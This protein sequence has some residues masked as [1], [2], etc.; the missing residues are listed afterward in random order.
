[1]VGILPPQFEFPDKNCADVI[2]PSALENYDISPTTAVRL[3][4]VVARLKPGVRTE[5]VIANLDAV[6]QRQ[7]ATYPA[8]FS[9]MLKGTHP[10]VMPLHERLVGK[11]RPALLVLLGAILF[12]LLI[13]CVN[14]A[15]L[16]LA[17]AVPRER[18]IAI[19]GA[20]GASRWQIVRQL[21]VENVL[22]AL[23]GGA[24]GFLVTAFDHPVV[25]DERPERHSS[26][27]RLTIDSSSLRIRNNHFAV[28]G[29][30]VRPCTN[31]GRFS[32]V[33]HRDNQRDWVD[34]RVQPKGPSF[35]WSVCCR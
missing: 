5:E 26:P 34:E 30:P 6:N 27:C 13:V 8:M 24:L 35:P 14:I 2:V 4:Q 25:E 9:G 10:V 23:A 15:S 33:G 11:S 31:S 12:V 1:M 20:L 3:V 18:E 21:L 17:R 22:I 32:H 7:W 19:R 16:Q 29:N 28:C